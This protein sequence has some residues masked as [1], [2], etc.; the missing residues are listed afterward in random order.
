MV[1]LHSL[2]ICYKTAKYGRYQKDW[3]KQEN[4]T[5]QTTETGIITAN[6]HKVAEGLSMYIL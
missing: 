2:F 1:P 6:L 5:R 4:I 3:I